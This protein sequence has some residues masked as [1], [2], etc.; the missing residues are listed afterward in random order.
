MGS[1]VS[2]CIFGALVELWTDGQVPEDFFTKFLC[3][4]SLLLS[5]SVE[6]PL[7]TSC[8]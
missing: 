3:T 4:Y 6:N 1:L 5:F 2:Y 8:A 7:W